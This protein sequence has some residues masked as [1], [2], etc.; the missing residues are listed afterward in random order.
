MLTIPAQFV[1]PQHD[2]AVQPAA[3]SRRKKSSFARKIA[4]RLHVLVL[5]RRMSM[6]SVEAREPA[7]RVLANLMRLRS[8]ENSEIHRLHAHEPATAR[9]NER[10]STYA[11]P[12]PNDHLLHLARE[13][14][15]VKN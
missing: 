3:K 11:P 7:R 4:V 14:S 8:V 6:S 15:S 2:L 1:Q 12:A 9:W 5:S 10:K 13:K